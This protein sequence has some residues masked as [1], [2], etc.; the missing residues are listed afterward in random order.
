MVSL[1]KGEITTIHQFMYYY[2]SIIF[3]N[4]VLLKYFSVKVG[5]EEILLQN[6]LPLLLEYPEATEILKL[7]QNIYTTKHKD[8]IKIYVH[9]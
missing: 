1:P 4:A 3:S 5:K 8:V 6:M 9:I 2:L 7:A